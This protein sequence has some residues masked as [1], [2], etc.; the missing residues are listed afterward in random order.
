M[1]NNQVNRIDL[2]LQFQKQIKNFLNFLN[3][4]KGLSENTILAYKNDIRNYLEYICGLN[5]ADFSQI[6]HHIINNFII[7]LYEL[8]LNET[9]RIRYLSSVRS[10]HKFLVENKTLK[11]DVSEKVIFPKSHKKL[12]EV[13]SYQEIQRLI[14]SIDVSTNAGIRDRAILEILYACGLRVSELCNLENQNIIWDYEILRIMG[15]G[16]KERIVPMGTTALFWLNEYLTKA[17]PNFI[18]ASGKNNPALFLNQRG[19]KLTRMGVWKILHNYA[20][21]IGLGDKVHPHIFRHSFA[22]HLLE[23]G[24]DLRAVQEMLGHSDISTTQIYTNID[25]EYIKSIHKKYHP[26]A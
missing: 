18:K 9:S 21:K 14:D 22:T 23:G 12:P 3:F 26:K 16:N 25:R 20:V 8:G 10:F 5:I 11:E 19:S 4:E 1:R 2:P 24:A 6:S 17:R 13:L 7:Y 15:K